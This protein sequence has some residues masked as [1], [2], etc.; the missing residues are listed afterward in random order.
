MLEALIHLGIF[1]F[2]AVILVA[3]ILILV[4]GLVAIASKSCHQPQLRI[5]KLNQ[6]YQDAVKP[7]REALLVKS[8]RKKQR[9]AEKKAKK[10]AKKAPQTKPN[11]F[12]LDF[13]G[14]IKAKATQQLR[15]EISAIL[16][17]AQ[18]D[19]E[20]LLR[21]ESAGGVMHGYGL[22][23]SQ[24]QRLR[25]KNIRLTIAI[26]KVAASGGY[27]MAC[28]ADKI[29]A[30]PFAIIGSIGV[31]AQLP[32]F[33]RFLQNKKI[34]F[35]Q[36]TAGEYKRTMTL[37]AENN[38]SDRAKMQD[39]I[40]EAHQLFKDFVSEHRP[41]LNI[42]KVATGEHWFATQAK[43]FGLVDELRTSDDYL[44]SKLDSTNLLQL[45]SRT[46]KKL[47]EKL[48]AAAQGLGERAYHAIWRRH[49]H[50]KLEL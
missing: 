19:D 44:L 8:E 20:V 12:V 14:D 4:S 1:F 37:F 26:D 33:Y 46:P 43:A 40:N 22:A 41:T 6:F 18:P 35:E 32:N 48:G 25:D 30:A 34:D 23:A 24:L 5:K 31:V 17:V 16:M 13:A 3:A 49:S 15:E 39:D 9:K 29:I 50:Q 38:D 36:L 27:M 47:H 21:L 11:L 2:E 45:Y 10:K 7:L 42:E 28:V